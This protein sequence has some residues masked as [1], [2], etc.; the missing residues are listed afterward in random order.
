MATRRALRRRSSSHESASLVFC[1][2]SFLGFPRNSYGDVNSHL[3]RPYTPGRYPR[4]LSAGTQGDPSARVGAPKILNFR[5][6]I[7]EKPPV[8]DNL[9]DGPPSVKVEEVQTAFFL[10]EARFDSRQLVLGTGEIQE[11]VLLILDGPR[12]WPR[13]TPN[14]VFSRGRLPIER[15]LHWESPSRTRRFMKTWVR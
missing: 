2:H 3:A 8:G 11:W 5:C 6:G 14:S 15:K 12:Y 1:T 4:S 13:S 9:R 7:A 10:V